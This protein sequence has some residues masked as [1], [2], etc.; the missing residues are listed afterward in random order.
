M[1]SRPGGR[2]AAVRTAVLAAA[3]DLLSESGVGAIELT[4][5]ADRAG[6]GTSTVYRRWGSKAALIAELLRDMAATSLPRAD[7]GTL[8]GDLRANAELVAKTLSDD[9]Q[10][11][12]FAALIAAASYDPDTAEALAEFYRSRIDEW[13]ACVDDAVRRGEAPAGTDAAAV[14]RA[15][16]APLYYQWL[17]LRTPPTQDDVRRAIDATLAAVAAGVFTV[18]GRPHPDS[19]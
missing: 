1:S 12:L 5:V 9:R 8:R 6:V 4:D 3:V 17:L 13:S 15:V 16:S 11:P 14:V 19:V 10:G 18:R 7:T 2:T